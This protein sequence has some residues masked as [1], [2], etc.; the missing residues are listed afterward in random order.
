[1]FA[2]LI[3]W[4]SSYLIRATSELICGHQGQSELATGIIWEASYSKVQ[5][6]AIRCNP[7]QSGAIRGNQR[8]S[9]AIRC[10]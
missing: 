5:S 10:K 2:A 4:E 1:M 7:V 6:G 3:I 9:D 8:Q